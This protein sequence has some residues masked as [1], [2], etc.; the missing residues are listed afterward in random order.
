MKSFNKTMI[1]LALCTIFFWLLSLP[2]CAQV[3]RVPS[4]AVAE[5][6][7]TAVTLDV[8]GAEN[9]RYAGQKDKMHTYLGKI[10][11]ESKLRFVIR[12]TLKN[13]K[14]LP[15]TGRSILIR[16]RVVAKKGETVLKSE[17]FK[18]ENMNSVF[19]N[20]TVPKDADNLE[21]IESFV[22]ANRSGD[23]KFNQK[24]TTINKLVLSVADNGS[25][26]A[27]DN[28]EKDAGP[29]KKET[30]GVGAK[31][32]DGS[33]KTAVG[34]AGKKN[35]NKND[36]KDGNGKGKDGSS[37]EAEA[38][39]RLTRIVS[40][41]AFLILL[42]AVGGHFFIKN[43]KSNKVAA[44][45]AARKERLR[46][47]AI[48]R[49]KELRQNGSAGNDAQ[50]SQPERLPEE[51]RPEEQ[52]T[53]APGWQTLPDNEEPQNTPQS[54]AANAAAA[55]GTAQAR[56]CRNCGAPLKPDSRFCENCGG[57]V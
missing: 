21:V 27:V 40:G 20:Y 56:F 32:G 43:R 2:C 50:Y 23:S 51:A 28:Q 45:T 6:G 8:E 30:P 5:Q 13:E 57:K 31:K 3:R 37:P 54:D 55:A 18:K 39:V 26:A 19:L 10:S 11:P 38:I 1:A 41:T 33:D 42:A 52:Q 36:G 44:E 14:E 15:I 12:A 46:Q 25:A 16:M 35:G 48:S 53:A 29:E 49:Q 47:Q 7:L 4:A 22:L 17:N 9:F 24:V 34:G